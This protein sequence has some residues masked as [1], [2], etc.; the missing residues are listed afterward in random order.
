MQ[1]LFL[2]YIA[3]RLSYRREPGK[4]N[5]YL[6]RSIT[7][8]RSGYGQIGANILPDVKRAGSWVS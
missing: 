5:S 4:P 8:H 3:A 1:T 2:S 7:I 6:A